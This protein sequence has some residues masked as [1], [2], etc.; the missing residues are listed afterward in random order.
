VEILGI[1][2]V[3][4]RS[5]TPASKAEVAATVMVVVVAAVM[6]VVVVAKAVRSAF[7]A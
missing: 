5:G 3:T 1:S 7:P 6:V 2:L 4:A